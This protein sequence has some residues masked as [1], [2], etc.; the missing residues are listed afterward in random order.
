MVL[1]WLDS[2]EFAAALAF[3][4]ANDKE[5][6]VKLYA[7]VRVFACDNGGQRGRDH[8]AQKAHQN[9]DIRAELPEA[10]DRYRE[11]T[12]ILA[13]GIEELKATCARLTPK[14]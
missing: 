13:R 6:A 14:R 8:S 10:F 4:H 3:R 7:G 9:F 2:N 12:L 11:S 1:N 5:E